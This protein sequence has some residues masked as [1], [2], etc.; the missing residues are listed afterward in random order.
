MKINLAQHKEGNELS[1][2]R[3]RGVK[4]WTG[5]TEEPKETLED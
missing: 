2:Y 3:K 4:S 1:G 5:I